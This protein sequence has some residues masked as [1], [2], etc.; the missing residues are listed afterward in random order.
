MGKDDVIHEAEIH[1]RSPTPSEKDCAKTAADNPLKI[2]RSLEYASGQTDRQV[3]TRTDI[4][5]SDSHPYLLHFN[6]DGPTGTG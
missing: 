3:D 2:W 1:L 6:C 5:E 4:L